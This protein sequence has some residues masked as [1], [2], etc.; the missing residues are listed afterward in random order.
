MGEVID[1]FSGRHPSILLSCGKNHPKTDVVVTVLRVVVVPVC[2]TTVGGVVVP[3]AAA[4]HAVR[5][6]G[7]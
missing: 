2:N 3:A 4:F 7:Q 6:R 1:R 5:A